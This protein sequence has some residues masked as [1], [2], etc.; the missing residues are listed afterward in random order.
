MRHQNELTE[1]L[2][3]AIRMLKTGKQ[4]VLTQEGVPIALIQP[5]RPV[6]KQEERAIQEM[7][8][9]GLLQTTDKSGSVREWRWKPVRAKAA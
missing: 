2:S 9:S 5:L 7:I 4:V 1:D 6:T 3:E 8:D